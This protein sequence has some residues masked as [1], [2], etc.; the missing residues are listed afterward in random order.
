[1]LSWHVLKKVKSKISQFKGAVL[2]LEEG[3]TNL[4]GL[5]LR[6]LIMFEKKLSSDGGLMPSEENGA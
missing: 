4:L 6:Q 1:L 2:H 3:T 5:K